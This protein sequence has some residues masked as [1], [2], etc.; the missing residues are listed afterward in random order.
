MTFTTNKM[1]LYELF[2]EPRIL[3]YHILSK[4][5][6]NICDRHLCHPQTL[7]NRGFI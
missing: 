3:D 5:G 7:S 6:Y 1:I 2:S 4:W